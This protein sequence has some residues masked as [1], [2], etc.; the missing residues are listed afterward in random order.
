MVLPLLHLA[1][2]C[3]KM[4]KG[5]ETDPFSHSPCRTWPTNCR[6]ATKWKKGGQ[7]IFFAAWCL[8]KG[9]ARVHGQSNR[10]DAGKEDMAGLFGLA[11]RG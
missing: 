10:E 5:T 6:D 4:K 11:S 9:R 2:A 1:I 7:P 3:Q 8:K